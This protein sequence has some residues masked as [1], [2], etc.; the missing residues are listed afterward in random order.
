MVTSSVVG[1]YSFFIRKKKLTAYIF[2]VFRMIFSDIGEKI[3][4]GSQA[5]SFIVLISVNFGC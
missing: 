2:V 3:V 5:V 4:E 1:F